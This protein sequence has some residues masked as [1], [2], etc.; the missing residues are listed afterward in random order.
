VEALDP[1]PPDQLSLREATPNDRGLLW[2]WAND[3]SVRDRSLNPSA[4]TWEEHVEWF[5]RTCAADDVRLL[6]VEADGL[7]VG[8]LRF[9]LRGG[10]A[11]INYSLDMCVRGRG[12]GHEIIE[13]GLQWLCDE[14]PHAPRELVALVRA[15]N[16]AS[17]RTFERLGFNR[18]TSTVDGATTHRFARDLEV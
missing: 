7:P 2:M 3:R 4:I 6:I 11:V 13:R 5:T 16:P 12:W 15:D 17:I 9:D 18:D 14:V 1:T 8:Q 10:D